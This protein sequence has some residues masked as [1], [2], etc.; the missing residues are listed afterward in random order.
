M[1]TDWLRLGW[2]EYDA[3]CHRLYQRPVFRNYFNAV[4]PRDD[5]ERAKMTGDRWRNATH[6]VTEVTRHTG[7]LRGMKIPM[8]TFAWYPFDSCVEKVNGVLR[9]PINQCLT[10]KDVF[11]MLLN[12]ELKEKV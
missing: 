4:P 3:D 6:K 12:D 10:T 8:S 5:R 1:Q 9:L 7:H 2:D 11:C